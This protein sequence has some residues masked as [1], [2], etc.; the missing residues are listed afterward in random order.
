MTSTVSDQAPPRAAPARPDQWFRT[1]AVILDSGTGQSAVA[2]LCAVDQAM[3]PQQQAN[4]HQVTSLV[5]SRVPLYRLRPGAGKLEL[6]GAH[7]PAVLRWQVTRGTAPVSAGVGIGLPGGDRAGVIYH[8][9]GRI[10]AGQCQDRL[11][12]MVAEGMRAVRGV[13]DWDFHAEIACCPPDPASPRAWRAAFAAVTFLDA[14][15]LGFYEHAGVLVP[16][17]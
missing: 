9:G 11:R 1:A 3:H 17:G 12:A 6:D 2:G 7:V 15:L 14:A 10:S 8:H 5:P 16:L 13:P 4:Y